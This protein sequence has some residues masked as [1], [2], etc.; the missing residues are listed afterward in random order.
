MSNIEFLYLLQ[1]TS[2][3]ESDSMP[4]ANDNAGT[5]KQRNARTHPALAALNYSSHSAAAVL[6]PSLARRAASNNAA[7]ATA[8]AAAAASTTSATA[9]NLGTSFPV[10]DSCQ[11]LCILCTALSCLQEPATC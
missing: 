4:F 6:S 8:A 7:A 11:E 1:S 9:S 3:T 10:L 2:S 5:I